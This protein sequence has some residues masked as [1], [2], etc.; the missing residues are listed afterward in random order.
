VA[1]PSNSNQLISY[2]IMKRSRGFPPFYKPVRLRSAILPRTELTVAFSLET[3]QSRYPDYANHCT[4]RCIR[5]RYPGPIPTEKRGISSARCSAVCLSP[6]LTKRRHRILV[7][8]NTSRW[9]RWL[10]LNSLTD[11][12]A[13]RQLPLGSRNM[14]F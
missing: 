12:Q 3:R 11:F 10:L 6:L 5:C 4:L 2:A 8:L 7:V 1:S 13:F 9:C 14:D